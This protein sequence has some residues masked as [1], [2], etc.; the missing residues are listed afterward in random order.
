MFV[1]LDP[2]LKLKG[3]VT[4]A[5]ARRRSIL[6]ILLRA[7]GGNKSLHPFTLVILTFCGAPGKTEA[8]VLNRL[9]T[10]FPH[11]PLSMGFLPTNHAAQLN[12]SKAIQSTTEIEAG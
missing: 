4:Q 8:V 9:P 1:R 7:R 5:R 6:K 3:T 10:N 2:P 11:S 12:I